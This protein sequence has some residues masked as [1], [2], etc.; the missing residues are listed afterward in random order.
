MPITFNDTTYFAG[1]WFVGHD[2]TLPLEDRMDWLAALWR[3]A[4][5]GSPWILQY[6]FRYHR[7]PD[8]HSDDDEKSWYRATMDASPAAEATALE[9][10]HLIAGITAHRNRTAVD[11]TALGCDGDTA[12]RKLLAMGK[13][14]LNLAPDD[15]GTQ[16]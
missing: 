13:S 6:R 2:E 10:V 11:F 7:S 3:D 9:A 1:I 8:P 5:P 14:W 4:T 16:R 15:A 12:I